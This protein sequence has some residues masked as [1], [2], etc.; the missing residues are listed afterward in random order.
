[1]VSWDVLTHGHPNHIELYGSKASLYI[2]DPDFFGGETV[3]TSGDGST[4][5][6]SPD[7]HPFGPDNEFINQPLQRANY[8][9]AGLADMLVA[10]DTGREPRCNAAL[11][12]HVID[13]L[14]GLNHAAAER[15]VVTM[16]TTCS[17]PEPLAAGEA[18]TLLAP[19]L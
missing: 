5:T 10:L 11:A 13:I 14:T 17:R 19:A 1:M 16:T 18:R 4:R 2:P 6:L 15:Q 9:G 7:D 12:L 8:R 3:I